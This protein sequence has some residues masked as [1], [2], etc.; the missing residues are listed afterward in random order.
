MKRVLLVLSQMPQ[1][2]ASGAARSMRTMCEMLAS[3]P[4]RFGVR[5]VVCSGTEHGSP[6]PV[7]RVLASAGVTPTIEPANIGPGGRP[8][9][10]RFEHHRVPYAM[11]DTG[12]TMA[13]NCNAEI[14]RAFDHLIDAEADAFGPDMVL[15]FGGQPGEMA[16][17][18]RLRARGMAIVFGLRNHGY[19][20][21]GAFKD[22]DAVVTPSRYLSGVYES[23]C[24]LRSTALPVPINESEVLAT[25]REPVMFTFVNPSPQ[26]GLMFFARLAEELGKRRPDI[27]LMVVESRGT[28]GTLVRAGQAGGFDLRRHASIVTSPGV[29]EPRHIYAATRVLLVPSV[30]EEPSGRVS[31]EAMLNGIPPIVSDR[32]GLPETVEDGGFV[33]PL[34]KHLTP[35]SMVPVSAAEVS[36]WAGLI[37]RLQDDEAFYQ[38]SCE[39]ARVA[40]ERLRF[41]ALAPRYAAFFESVKRGAGATL[42]PGV[43]DNQRSA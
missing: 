12:A 11:L 34:P 15:T 4:D 37:E 1:D 43:A 21:H 29:S 14:N 30:W 31:G 28:A 20:K 24:G 27:G 9:V 22:C 13:P 2:P 25:E 38:D 17:R 41:E 10:L 18:A 33:L 6:E 32:G 8:R 35:E 26:K 16:R 36:A 19:L 40:G 7:E 23:F 3:F 5:A 42:G 39:R